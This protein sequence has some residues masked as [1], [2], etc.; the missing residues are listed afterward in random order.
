MKFIS[1][2]LFL[3]L[4]TLIMSCSNSDNSTIAGNESL[5]QDTSLGNISNNQNEDS[6]FGDK[7]NDSTVNSDDT[8]ST[9]NPIDKDDTAVVKDTTINNNGDSTIVSDSNNTS[10]GIV[11]NDVVSLRKALLNAKAGDHIL[12]APGIYEAPDTY[13]LEYATMER[14][15]Y[16]YSQSSGTADKPIT[17]ESLKSDDKA[18]L[19]G[20]TTEGSKFILWIKGEYWV[21]KNISLKT[22]GKGLVLDEASNS[23]ID[24]VEVSNIGDEGIHLRSGSSNCVV[25][26]SIVDGTGLV[27][28]GFGEGIYIGSDRSQHYKYKRECNN[29]IIENCTIKNTRAEA[30]DVKEATTGTIIKNCDI[31]GGKISGTQNNYADSFIDLKG[32][33]AKVFGNTFYREGNDLV[34]RGVAIVDRT[35]SEYNIDYTTTSSNN[36]IYENKFN[37]EIAAGWMVHAYRGENNYAWDNTRDVPGDEDYKGKAP[38]LYIKDPRN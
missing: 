4:F 1:T 18:I 27:Q 8:V 19:K 25:K 29:N 34:T 15:I 9:N 24:G 3:F 36:W 23:I 35:S 10:D 7:D 16:F 5:D 33:W 28:P 14:S 13:S 31:Y 21:I 17:I 38:E 32:V 20:D 6:T 30:V 12:I 22:G 26:N 2:T 37:L 11:V